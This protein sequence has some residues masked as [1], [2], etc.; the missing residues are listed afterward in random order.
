[1]TV[2]KICKLLKNE[3]LGCLPPQRGEFKVGYGVQLEAFSSSLSFDS[4]ITKK[5]NQYI[6]NQ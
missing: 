6:S 2:I 3:F 1:M 4:E 5:Q